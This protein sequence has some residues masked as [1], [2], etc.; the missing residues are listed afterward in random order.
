MAPGPRTTSS[1]VRRL[2]LTTVARNAIKM[3]KRT[4][5]SV[6]TVR[7]AVQC[8]A[9]SGGSKGRTNAGYLP[10]SVPSALSAPHLIPLPRSLAFSFILSLPLYSLSLCL[11]PGFSLA[12]QT[13]TRCRCRCCLSSYYT[14]MYVVF[15]ALDVAPL[16]V[17]W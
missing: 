6:G 5:L 12:H 17:E 11:S 3:K 8:S 1:L 10:C 9:V 2:D 15:I 7:S 16:H 13:Q 14:A 4:A